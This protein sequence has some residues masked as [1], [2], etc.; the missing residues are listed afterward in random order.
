MSKIDQVNS[1]LVQQTDEKFQFEEEL[2]ML[3]NIFKD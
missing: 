2:E 3:K 1:F